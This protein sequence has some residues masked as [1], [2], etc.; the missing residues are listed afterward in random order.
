M[1]KIF[2]LVLLFCLSKISFAQYPVNQFIGSDSTLVTSRG[3]LKSR[4]INSNFTDTT[5]A[6]LQR[7]PFAGSNKIKR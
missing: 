3:A 5:A 2:L 4:L 1:K 6:N 7:I